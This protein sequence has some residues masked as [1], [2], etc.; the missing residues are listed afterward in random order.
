MKKPT[1]LYFVYWEPT[2]TV[3]ST[4]MRA[5]QL[6]EI[7]NRFCGDEIEARLMPLPRRKYK[8]HRHLWAATRPRDAIYFVSKAA[9]RRLTPPLAA[10]LRRRARSLWYDH[11]DEP[12]ESLNRIGADVHICCSVHQHD[13]LSRQLNQDPE[14]TGQARLILHNTDLRLEGR[15]PAQQDSFAALYLGD[16]VN[17][18]IP[19][20][21]Q[22]EIAV[23]SV[24]TT[25]EFDAAL[26]RVSRFNL[27]FNHRAD[28]GGHSSSIKPFVKGFTAA[29]LGANILTQRSTT[30]AEHFLGADYPYY[31]EGPGGVE[32]AFARARDG[33]GGPE[34]REA[35][36][37]MRC[38]RD[39]TRPERIAAQV[40]DLVRE[41][42]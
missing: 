40:R 36:D 6:S 33:F 3:G 11:V 21:L 10:L 18:A 29:A 17:S 16:P 25:A 32:A 24:K 42:S 13:L 15:A 5:F 4:V 41:C 27:H 35:R 37:R 19:P 34:W 14:F 31:S 23:E 26:D 38:M 12:M 2:A 20:Q 9:L 30:D 39:Q 8:G 22:P 7:V 1:R 28:R